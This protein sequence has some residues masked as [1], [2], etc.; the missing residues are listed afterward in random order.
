MLALEHNK[1]YLARFKGFELDEPWLAPL[2][3]RAIK[4]HQ[5]PRLNIFEFYPVGPQIYFKTFYGAR[6]PANFEILKE[7]SSELVDQYRKAY[8]SM[9]AN[10]E[11]DLKKL[12]SEYDNKISQSLLKIQDVLLTA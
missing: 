5:D 4:M 1:F 9:I 10:R 2:I 7:V 11:E 8:C 3:C 6:D 12:T